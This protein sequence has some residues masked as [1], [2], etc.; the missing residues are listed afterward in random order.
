M[1]AARARAATSRHAI[2]TVLL[3]AATA[4]KGEQGSGLFGTGT[5]TASGAVEQES[6]GPVVIAAPKSGYVATA[7]ASPATVTGTVTLRGTLAPAEP[8]LTG[9]DSVACGRAIPDSSV[10]QRGAGLGNVVVWI[11]ELR[12]GKPLPLERRIELESDR[13]ILTPRVQ[14]AVVG[15]AVNVIGHDDFRQHLRFIAG[16]DTASRAVILLGRD[17]QVIP[18]D[19][20]ARRPGL[21]I[22]RDTDHPW[23]RAYL[24]VFDHPYF[25]VTK[26]DGAFTIEGVPPGR[27]SLVSWHERTGKREQPLEVTGG[28][29]RVSVEMEG[30]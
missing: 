28:A 2:C 1:T 16:G 24:A 12:R 19:L 11:D 3:L 13:C 7:V 10:Q 27:Y 26:P 20:L 30:R 22:A 6:G 21:V 25:A 15:S 14:A 18:T 5:R 4:C 29:V 17:E 8:A 23:P 9:R